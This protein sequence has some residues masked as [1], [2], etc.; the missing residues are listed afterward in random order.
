MVVSW[1]T[2][3]YIIFPGN[4]TCFRRQLKAKLKGINKVL[5]GKDLVQQQQQRRDR[6]RAGGGGGGGS[7][8]TTN[9]P[10]S[11]RNNN[12]VVV[13]LN[14][15]YEPDREVGRLHLNPRVQATR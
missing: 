13:P 15:L 7:A 8:P 6:R 9:R 11:S 1:T 3:T 2:T 4:V 5:E 10:G 12:R 14:L